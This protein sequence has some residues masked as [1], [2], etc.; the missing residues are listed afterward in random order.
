MT[1]H[2]R[3]LDNQCHWSEVITKS[4]DNQSEKKPES[5]KQ[6]NKSE[7]KFDNKSEKDT[8]PTLIWND[9]PQKKLLGPIEKRDW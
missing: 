6:V 2:R 4:F 5:Q 8:I 3:S 1:G 9:R 7:K